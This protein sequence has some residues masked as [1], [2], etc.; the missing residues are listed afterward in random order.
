[1][2]RLLILDINGIAVYKKMKP[3]FGKG[4][5]KTN[6]IHDN[7]KFIEKDKMCL[8]IN[9]YIKDFILWC[10]DENIDIGIWSSTY[11]HNAEDVIKFIMTEEERKKL[12]FEWYRDRTEFDPDYGID[13]NIRGHDTVKNLYLV[14]CNPIVNFRNYD[15]VNDN[16]DHD[17]RLNYK[18]NETNTI[19]LE[20]NEKKVRFN[21]KENVIIVDSYTEK[22]NINFEELKVKVIDRFKMLKE[23]IV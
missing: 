21:D 23:N 19:I 20:D 8:Y 15:C 7:N 1:M 6:L 3:K 5:D 14:W 4:K 22:T 16:N 13:P 9:P 10:F 2:N 11:K 18:Y 12:K 17:N